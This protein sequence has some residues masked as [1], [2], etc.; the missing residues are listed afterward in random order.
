[1]YMYIDSRRV[2]LGNYLCV[3]T[4]IWFRKCL[5]YNN[6]IFHRIMHVRFYPARL[7][8]LQLALE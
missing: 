1:M 7:V 4:E 8:Y 3:N 6:I 5:T 2:A